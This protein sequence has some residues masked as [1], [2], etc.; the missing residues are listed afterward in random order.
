MKSTMS[1]HAS[2]MQDL[3]VLL[4]AR[5]R[6]LGM[7]AHVADTSITRQGDIITV[8]TGATVVKIYNNPATASPQTDASV[9]DALICQ[10][11]LCFMAHVLTSIEFERK[12]GGSIKRMKAVTAALMQD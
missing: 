3:A 9:E 10:T 7:D 11:A 4:L 6:R 1:T 5:F 12:L 2:T 8:T